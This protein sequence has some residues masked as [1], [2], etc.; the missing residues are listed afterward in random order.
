[1]K[2]AILCLTLVLAGCGVKASAPVP[3]PPGAVNSI[4][5]QFFASLSAAQ[6]TL[7]SLKASEP[8]N[9]QIKTALNQ[10]I[11]DYNL[12]EVAYQTFHAALLAG[13]TP[14][15]SSVQTSINQVQSDLAGIK[16]Q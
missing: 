13:Q 8:A 10:A 3:P 16:V 2:R 7:N 9:P 12:A 15:S 11:E 5:A 1:M 14:D 4:D 6:A